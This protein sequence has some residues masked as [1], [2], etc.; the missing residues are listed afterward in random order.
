MGGNI[1]HDVRSTSGG[2]HRAQSLF[3]YFLTTLVIFQFTK[4]HR[5]VQYQ[6]QLSS[7]FVER[8]EAFVVYA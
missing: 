7:S 2:G 6:F 5:S 3:E 8:L 4:F 1:C